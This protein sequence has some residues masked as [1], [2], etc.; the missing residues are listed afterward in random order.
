MVFIFFFS[1]NL[2]RC[3]DLKI[4]KYLIS[5]YYFLLISKV[6][7]FKNFHLIR[8]HYLLLLLC[9]FSSFTFLN[10]I[11]LLGYIYCFFDNLLGLFHHYLGV[12]EII[13]DSSITLN[14]IIVHFRNC[15]NLLLANSILSCHFNV[16]NHQKDLKVFIKNLIK[17]KIL[18]FLV[19]FHQI[20]IILHL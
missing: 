6:Y 12:A 1:L 16:Q 9:Y 11:M 14:S 4:L 15:F 10:F 13:C 8:K 7:L 18:L 3:A 5:L 19:S 20:K 2:N 17:I